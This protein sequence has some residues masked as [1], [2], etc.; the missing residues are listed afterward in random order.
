MEVVIETLE[1]HPGSLLVLGNHDEFLLSTVEGTCETARTDYWMTELGGAETIRSYFADASKDPD[2]IAAM[3]ASTFPT[4]V[5]VLRSA[6]D[7]VLLDDN[8][9]LVHAGVEP[10]IP[11]AE[12]DQATV[13]WIREKFLCYTG[14]YER[15]V[16]HGH[17]ITDE[18]L[19]AEPYP[20]RIALD[21]GAYKGGPLCSV[22]IAGTEEPRFIFAFGYED[23]P[24]I[25]EHHSEASLA[26]GYRKL[27][28]A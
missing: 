12:Q 8:W 10:G 21:A 17:S 5:D 13:R 22:R 23:D 24:I 26:I 27:G 25:V 3:M 16:V 2:E 19:G 1:L 6:A 11:F 7:M 4:H 9:C 15:R 20:N 28:M 18:N 14:P